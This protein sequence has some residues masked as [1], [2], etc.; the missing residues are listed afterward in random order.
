[1]KP[2]S[3]NARN[4]VTI[5]PLVAARSRRKSER[6][7]EKEKERERRESAEAV[8]F[9]LIFFPVISRIESTNI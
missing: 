4:L 3:V 7:R 2:S 9:I 8:I 6:E 1:M 5:V